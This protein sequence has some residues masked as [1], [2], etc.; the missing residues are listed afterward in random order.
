MATWAART[1]RRLDGSVG[2]VVSYGS[3]QRD[4]DGVSDMANTVAIASRHCH[5]YPWD[6]QQPTITISGQ[7]RHMRTPR[8]RIEQLVR[9]VARQEKAPLVEVDI[10]VVD[11][12][13]MA[14]LN[15]RFLAHVGTTDVISFDL[16]DG[17]TIAAEIIVCAQVAV[18][19]AARRGHGR[20]RELLLY[21]THGLLHLMGYDDQALDDARRMR[22]RQEQLLDAFL[23]RARKK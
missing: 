14:A 7:S 17:E 4:W 6:M 13:R 18:R 1:Q 20:Q 16:G 22:A 8:R 2:V 15:R 19:E 12:R 9:F 21:V 5:R 23:K 11:S 10:A 3:D